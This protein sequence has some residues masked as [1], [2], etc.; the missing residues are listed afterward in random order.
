MLGIT[1]VSRFI[2]ITL[3]AVYCI[4]TVCNFKLLPRDNPVIT[5]IL[6]LC[7]QSFGK[8]PDTALTTEE[9]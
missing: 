1:W 4:T 9:L 6:H 7:D 5:G 3:D 8:D 2:P